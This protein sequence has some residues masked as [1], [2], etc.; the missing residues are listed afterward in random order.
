[1]LELVYAAWDVQPFAQ[2]LGYEGPPFAWDAEQR[3]LLRTKLDAY[4][5]RLY[6]LTR[7]QLRYILDSHDLTDHELRTR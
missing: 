5:A 2:D 1:V 3:A 7:K 4:Y 6:G